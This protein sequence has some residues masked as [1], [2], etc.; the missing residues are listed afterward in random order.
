[1]LTNSICLKSLTQPLTFDLEGEILRENS[2]E[3]TRFIK[4]SLYRRRNMPDRQK[5]LIH[6]AADNNEAI[7]V[8]SRAH[9]LPAFASDPANIE[10]VTHCLNLAYAYQLTLLSECERVV[11]D[12]QEHRSAA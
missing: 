6:E 7:E 4:Q 8:L 12:L 5:H 9:E 1:M 11:A 2:V 10:I 3:I